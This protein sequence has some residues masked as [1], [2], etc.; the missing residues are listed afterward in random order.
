MIPNLC[1][2]GDIGVCL[3]WTHPAHSVHIPMNLLLTKTYVLLIVGVK[4]SR[5][6]CTW[7]TRLLRVDTGGLRGAVAIL[8]GQ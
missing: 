6:G 5:P 1:C 3:D 4:G 7:V 8:Q 2:F